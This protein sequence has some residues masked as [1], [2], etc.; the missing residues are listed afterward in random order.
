M[1]ILTRKNGEE[2]LIGENIRLVVMKI[3]GNRI[4]LGLDAPQDVPIRRGELNPKEDEPA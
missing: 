4:K 3:E 2:I 1:L